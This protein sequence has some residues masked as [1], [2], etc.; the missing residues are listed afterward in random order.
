MAG[1]NAGKDLKHPLLDLSSRQSAGL[2]AITNNRSEV[3]MKVLENEYGIFV[4]LPEVLDEVDHIGSVAEDLER[5]NLAEGAL[6]V[7]DFLESDEKP[8]GEP[9][10]AVNIGVGSRA[11]PIEDLIMLSDLSAAVYAPAPRG[12]GRRSVHGYSDCEGEE[13]DEW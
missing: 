4:L 8:V 6:V 3:S 11:N 10:A 12:L 2:L 13:G 1:I 9:A 5:L 7:V